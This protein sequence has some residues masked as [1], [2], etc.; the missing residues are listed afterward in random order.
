[1]SQWRIH[2]WVFIGS[3]WILG[4]TQPIAAQVIPDNTLPLGERSQVSGNPNFQIDGG[5]RRGGNLFHSFQS[6]SVPTGGT[7][8]FNN[9]ADVQNIFS[10]VT[11]GSISN[12]DGVMRANGTA[13]LFFLNPNGI[14]FGAN[15]SLNIGGSFVATTANAIGFANGEFFSSDVTQPLP[16]QLL[17]VNLNAF[18]FNQLTPQLIVNQSTANETGLQVSP[19]QN[20]LLIGGSVQLDGGRLTSPGSY[21]EL[22]SVGGIGTVGLSTTGEDWRL[23]FPDN[24]VRADVSLSNN[25]RINVLA[26]GAGSIAVTSRNLTLSGG[27]RLRVGIDEGLGFVGAQAGDIQLDA[28]ETINVLD[29]STIRNEVLPGGNGNGGPI[30]I[31]TGSLSLAGDARL[32]SVTSGQGD[33]G[34]VNINARDSVSLDGSTVFN[35]VQNNAIGNTGNINI[36]TGSLSLTGGAQLILSARGQG[37]VGSVNINARDR[38]SL[39]SSNVINNVEQ[40]GVGN[41]GNI[42]IT[43]KSLS[44]TGGAQLIS[45]T[46]GQGNAG[47]VNINANDRVSLDGESS[48]GAVASTIFTRVELGSVGQGGNVTIATGSLFLTNGGAVNTANVG[49]TGNAGRVIIHAHDSVQISGTA[50][51]LTDNRSGIFT[52][53]TP[54]SLGNGGDVIITTG[55]L[56]VS[57]QGRI[58]TNAEAQGNAG[59]IQIQASNTVLFN[60]GDAVSTLEPGAMGKGGNINITARSLSLFNGAQLS[61]TTSG[62]GDAGN[63]SIATL[64]TVNLSGV[65]FSGDASGLFTSTKPLATGNGGEIRVETRNLQVTSGGVLNAQSF[66]S[67]RG[68]DI[69]VSA[70]TVGLSGGGQLLTTTSSN[71]HAGDITVNTPDLQLSGTTSGLFAGTTSAGDAGSLTI[72]PRGNGQSVRVNLQDGGQI[73]ASTSSSGDGGRLTI[74]APESITLTGDGSIIA[75]GTGGSGA[76]G[77]LNLQTGTLSI[78]NQAEVTVSSSGTGNAG[79]LSVDANRIY[80]NNHSSIRADTTGGGGNIFLRTPLLL[81]RNG[82][83]ITTNATGE[84]IPGGNIDIDAKNGFIIAVPQEN[85]DIS[86]NSRDFRGGNVTINAQA[87]FGIKPKNAS[88]PNSDITATGKNSSDNGTVQVN[89]PDVDPSNGLVELPAN[90]VDRSSLIA[91][92]CPANKGNSFTITGRGGLPPL[93][94]QALRTNQTATVD[95]VTL[96]TQEQKSTNV[97]DNLHLSR[98]LGRKSP[99]LEVKQISPTIVE[100]TSWVINNSGTVELI[101]SAPVATQTT[102]TYTSAIASSGASLQD[103]TRSPITACPSQATSIQK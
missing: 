44:L 103:A 32:I 6:F 40:T 22:G 11:G 20:L 1:M 3:V 29:G 46:D 78:Q 26:G 100:A 24:I 4:C 81:L 68:G 86:A 83:A 98:S 43:T 45:S 69:I 72:Q 90:F 61:A 99:Q 27:S 36:T 47:S 97:G 2:R 77:D 94:T 63:I 79:S 49:G 80:L 17:S 19:R 75:A 58:I 48:D 51:T 5:A 9:A 84:N 67:G 87:I 73:S 25:A 34:S 70:D 57:D 10:R 16:S 53:A 39:D 60:G 54:G 76:G 28:A 93:P 31:T 91:Q 38:V 64:D 92:G 66:S 33:V 101:A 82:S 12:I 52:S 30:T 71:G 56:S 8:Y 23:S 15:A 55:S 35:A 102:N 88:T 95:W 37:D 18:F 7:A 65:N 89:T 74:A 13:N 85:S 50:P 41:A 42:N 21:V 96:N 59:N 62:K 14:I